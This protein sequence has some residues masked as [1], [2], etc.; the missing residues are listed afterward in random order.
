VS[1][2]RGRT[3]KNF[4]SLYGEGYAL[5]AAS[6]NV[7]THQTACINISTSIMTH[8]SGHSCRK[9]HVRAIRGVLLSVLCFMGDEALR[10]AGDVRLLARL[11]ILSWLAP[12]QQKRLAAA[13]ATYDVEPNQL[14]FSDDGGPLSDVFILLSGAARLSCVGPKRGRIAIALLS[15]GVIAK[16]PALAHFAGHFR[17]DALRSSRIGRVAQ[18]V[19]VEIVLGARLPEFERLAK[20]PFG[21]VENLLTRYP[22]F[23]GLGLRA[24]VAVALLDLGRAFG[25]QDSRGVLLTTAPTLQDLAGLVGASR[26]KINAVLSEFA[27]LGAIDRV[28]RRTPW[29]RR[30]LKKSPKAPILPMHR[31]RGLRDERLMKRQEQTVFCLI[32]ATSNSAPGR[33]LAQY[34]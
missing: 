1:Q 30:A 29:F 12:T 24:R 26:P 8:S 4:M 33:R 7:P 3:F 5:F 2:R 14:I 22:G 18:D 19:L 6:N 34:S 25:V 15:P 32:S 28:G 20:L 11:S 9:Y 21:G 16:P 17:C 23:T 27:R 13:V 10:T 31:K